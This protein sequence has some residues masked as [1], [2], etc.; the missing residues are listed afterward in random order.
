MWFK[1]T[2]RHIRSNLVHLCLLLIL[3]QVTWAAT[4]S[5]L[6]YIY[7]SAMSLEL[8]CINTNHWQE[9]WQSVIPDVPTCLDSPISWLISLF[10]SANQALSLWLIWIWIW[11]L[12]KESK[13]CK[14]ETTTEI[15]VTIWP[16]N[17]TVS[18]GARYHRNLEKI[19]YVTQ[20][21]L[22]FL[23]RT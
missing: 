21:M 3:L 9:A 18:Q 7:A 13:L 17:R 8:I 5:S 14:G 23:I 1:S 20:W 22:C 2:I 6:I 4:T 19:P 15:L 16:A 11:K 12:G 10:F